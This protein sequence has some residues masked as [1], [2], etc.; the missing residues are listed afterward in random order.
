MFPSSNNRPFLVF[1]MR[2][3]LVKVVQALLNMH[4]YY[5]GDEEL[6][7]DGYYAHQTK[8]GVQLFQKDY[9]HRETGNL[10]IQ[11]FEVL[12]RDVKI[13]LDPTESYDISKAQLN[14][15]ANYPL[16]PWIKNINILPSRRLFLVFLALLSSGVVVFAVARN[17]SVH[18]LLKD[19]I[20][21]FLDAPTRQR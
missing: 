6:D 17:Y 13:I 15:S 19:A 16:E 21:I 11:E 14:V 1:G 7:I 9:G 18:L 5:V 3:E 10:T 8:A 20:E 4:G 2:S 12:R